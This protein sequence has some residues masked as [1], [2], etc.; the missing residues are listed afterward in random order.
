MACE[1]L[2]RIRRATVDDASEIATVHVDSWREAYEG[3]VPREILDGLNHERRETFWRGTLELTSGDHRPW[4]AENDR[5][6]VGFVSAGLSRDQKAPTTVGEVYELYVEPECWSR[7][8]GRELLGHAVKD[9][10][11]HGF[12]LATAWIIE[13]SE[14]ARLFYERAGWHFDGTR[15]EVPIGSARIPEVRYRRH[16]V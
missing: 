15:R 8:I 6:I 5:G 12:R 2:I 3:I 10:R 9:L 4:I 11:D 13:D 16:L 1:G 7:G 14:R